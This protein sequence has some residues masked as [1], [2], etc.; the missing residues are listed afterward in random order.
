KE[1]WI[2]GATGLIDDILANTWNA[3]GQLTRRESVPFGVFASLQYDALGNAY[4]VDVLG[5]NGFLLLSNTY[6]FLSPVKS[7]DLTLRG[8]P[9]G[10]QF[11]NYVFNPRRQTSAKAVV[12]DVNGN[13]FTLFDQ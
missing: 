8:L 13:L 11:L 9:Y 2:N 6:T 4:Q 5:T 7:P 12:S 3:K 1:V 10:P